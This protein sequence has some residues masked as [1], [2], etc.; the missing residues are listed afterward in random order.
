MRSD[1]WINLTAGLNRLFLVIQ[2]VV[3]AIFGTIPIAAPSFIGFGATSTLNEAA[4]GGEAAVFVLHGTTFVEG[5]ASP[6]TLATA[7]TRAP[8]RAE[9]RC[10]PLELQWPM[11]AGSWPL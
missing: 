1:T 9:G 4:R 6:D 5:N 8:P 3:P 2:L 10:S 11:S 7:T